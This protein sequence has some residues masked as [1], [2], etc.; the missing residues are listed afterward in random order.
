MFRFCPYCGSQIKRQS[1]DGFQCPNCKK[2]THYASSPAVSVAVK[3][4]DE[5]L[6]AVRGREPGK[7]EMDLVGG[8][9]EYG[10]AP[11]K[12]AVR[13]FKEE[14]GISLDPSKLNFL[15]MWV[16]GYFY[17]G[18]NQLI[19]NIV[20]LMEMDKKFKGKPADDVAELVWVPLSNSPN[21]AFSYLYKVWQNLKDI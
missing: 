19:L 10:E 21:F 7:G 9:L 17:Q 11:I 4:G 16:D 8:F 13:E 20:Y 6:V 18:Q 3:V 5:G 15:G 14:V 12:A 2:W 1:K